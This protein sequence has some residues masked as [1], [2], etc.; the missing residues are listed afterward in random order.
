[1]SGN[2]LPRVPE[3]LY[4]LSPLK[5]LNLSNNQ[6]TELSLVIDTWVNL[7]TLNLSRNKLTALPSSLHKLVALKK[8]YINSN[9]LDFDGIPANIGKLHNLEV[10]SAANN[11]IEMK[12]EGLFRCGK[13][14]RLLLNG[15]RLVTL[16]D[17]L[18][19]LPE[20]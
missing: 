10:F 13:L 19:L 16:P 6:I 2:D 11:N 7:E 5:R 9:Q 18:H 1:L 4:K 12:P 3:T 20:L 8:L 17:I 15:N 14:K